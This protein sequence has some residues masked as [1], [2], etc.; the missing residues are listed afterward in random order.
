MNL[1][2]SIVKQFKQPHGAL[3]AVAGHIMACRP[4]N[5]ER[6]HW[7]LQLLDLQ[8]DDRLLEVGFGPGIAI[9][10]AARFITNGQIVGIDHSDVMLKQASKRNA[11]AIARGQVELHVGT[12]KDLPPY[13]QP[14]TKMCSANVVQFWQDPTADF[15]KLR[16]ILVEG[17]VIATTYMPRHSHATTA[18]AL[19]KA[20]EIVEHLKSAGFVN[21]RIEENPFKPISA[22]SVVAVNE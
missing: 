9:E 6:N 11:Q 16:S 7:T 3:G 2:Q 12:I 14:F 10:E 18:D 5:V 20:N 13:S 4:S 15:A 17:G 1:R 22:I 19:S 21:I 8:P